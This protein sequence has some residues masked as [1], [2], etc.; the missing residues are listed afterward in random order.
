MILLLLRQYRIVEIGPK[1][2]SQEE[3]T[4]SNSAKIA[5]FLSTWKEE[6]EGHL[7]WD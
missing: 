7:S 5:P 3:K 1:E 2:T 4:K 6:T